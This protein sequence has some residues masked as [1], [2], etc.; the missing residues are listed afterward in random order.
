[1]KIPFKLIIVII[2]YK[3]KISWNIFKIV[4]RNYVYRTNEK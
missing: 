4:W 3:K 2:Q 1:M